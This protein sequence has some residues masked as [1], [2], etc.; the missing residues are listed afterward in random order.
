MNL[1]ARLG[2]LEQRAGVNAGEPRL[3]VSAIPACEMLNPLDDETIAAML[4]AGTASRM[5]PCVFI[6]GQKLTLEEW[7]ARNEWRTR[8]TAGQ[9]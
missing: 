7:K 2:H 8:Q 3:I 5:G 9:A 1:R 4:A 6:R